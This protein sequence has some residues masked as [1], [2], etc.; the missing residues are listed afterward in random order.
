MALA[1]SLSFA[2]AD[3]LDEVLKRMD[4]AA[5]QFKSM[6]AN[7]HRLTYLARLDD[8]DEQTG[9]VKMRLTNNGPVA[10]WIFSDKDPE[11]IFLS[12]HTVMKYL[13]K[14]NMAQVYNAG[15]NEAVMQE[16]LLLG[17]GARIEKLKNTYDFTSGGTEKVEG[18]NS[19]WFRLTPKK[20]DLKDLFTYID[21]WIPD[22]ESNPIQE[23]IWTGTKG[24]Y[25]L[26]TY[27][28]LKINPNLP[29]SDFQFKP[30]PGTEIKPIN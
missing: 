11:T 18:K 9:T 4:A 21:L 14:A 12:G 6:T 7:I 2:R 16:T 3:S 28:N 1:L 8:K 13:P 23:K 5:P 26:A 24:N 22:G 19:T 20:K 25:T 29:D 15:K 17:F 30:P 27:S 10:L